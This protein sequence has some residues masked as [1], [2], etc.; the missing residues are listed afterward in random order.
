MARKRESLWAAYSFSKLLLPVAIF[1]PT[2]PL[3]Y[4]TCTFKAKQDIDVD[5]PKLPRKRNVPRKLDEGSARADFPTDGK[6]YYRQSYFEALDFA[7]SIIQDHFDQPDFSIYRSLEQLLLNTIRGGSTQEMY[8]FV[9]KLNNSDFD[10]QRLQL[11]LETLQATF[12][13]GR[14]PATLCINDLKCFILSLSEN[15]RAVIGEVV[16]LLR[17]ILVLPST[18]AVSECSFSAMRQLKTYLRTTMTQERL[19]HL[20][21]LHIHKD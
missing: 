10:C 19:N 5:G 16:T 17:L 1:G 15:E 12:P 7:I 6:T 3:L 8:D 18:N 21:L 4:A 13:E 9:C 11:H 2:T 20:L 14:K